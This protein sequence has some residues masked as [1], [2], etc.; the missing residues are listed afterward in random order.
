M[1]KFSPTFL[2][3]I[4]FID[5]LCEHQA[6]ETPDA[7][8]SDV[9]AIDEWAN[10]VCEKVRQIGVVPIGFRFG[11][12]DQQQGQER[13]C[14]LPQ[15]W[16]GLPGLSERLQDTGLTSTNIRNMTRPGRADRAYFLSYQLAV[17]PARLKEKVL[18]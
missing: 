7:A 1:E 9:R 13:L 6:F 15:D 8:S 11:D 2:H 5:W 18:S 16:R 12:V 10:D 4:Q 14:L 3:P 17:R